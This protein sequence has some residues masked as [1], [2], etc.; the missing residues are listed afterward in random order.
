[1]AKVKEKDPEKGKSPQKPL[2]PKKAKKVQAKRMKKIRKM[3]NKKP[4][5]ISLTFCFFILSLLIIANHYFGVDSKGIILI[6]LNPIL[7]GISYTEFGTNVLSNGP[8]I[9]AGGISIYWYIAHLVTFVLY[10]AVLDV[11][12][13]L[14]KR[15]I[16]LI[17]TPEAEEPEVKEP[18][19]AASEVK[20][21][22]RKPKTNQQPNQ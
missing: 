9:V 8:T 1:M 12:K 11:I 5:S 21:V 10:G 17:K 18:E 6:G 15:L 3:R 22:N 20:E 7:K 2:S 4:F 19:A 16:R 13:A 14:I